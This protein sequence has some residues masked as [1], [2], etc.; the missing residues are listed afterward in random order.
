MRK[1]L[2]GILIGTLCIGSL[3]ACGKNTSEEKSSTLSETTN[4]TDETAA[5]TEQVLETKVSDLN[6]TVPFT[7]SDIEWNIE[8]NIVN[9][10]RE[11]AISYTNNT[12]YD[13]FGLDITYS[14]KSGITDEQML[15][16]FSDVQS[17]YDYEDSEIENLQLNACNY[18]CTVSGKKADKEASYVAGDLHGKDFREI[19]EEQ[20][21]LFE[22]DTAEIHYIS[23]GKIYAVYYDFKNNEM[24]CD[25][26]DSIDKFSWSDSDLA[27]AIPKPEYDIVVIIWE[28]DKTF[29]CDICNVTKDD[30]DNYREQCIQKGFVKNS[31]NDEEY[32]EAENS[33]G[34][35]LTMYYEPAAN[36]MFCGLAKRTEE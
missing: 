24:D 26:A 35:N 23:G 7:M 17:E 33:D 15:N 34:I 10:T 3:S 16:A 27:N 14:R 22:P 29:S 25:S 5:Q 2:A 31:S 13:I 20:F 28:D 36:L 1:I 8:E 6:D 21:N 11:Y 19:T 12:K 9:G 4:S 18:A 30:F 32:Y